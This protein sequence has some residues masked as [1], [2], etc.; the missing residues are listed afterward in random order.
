MDN[1][2]V[3]SN[4]YVAGEPTFFPGATEREHRCLVTVIK[5]RGKNKAGAEM[6]DEFSL[7]FWGKYACMAANYLPKGRAINVEGQLRSFTKDTGQVKPNG[8]PVLYRDTTIHV[9]SFEFSRD[10]RKT[11]IAIV[12][13]NILAAKAAGLL[14][15]NATVTAE[16]LLNQERPAYADFN[17]GIAEQSGKYVH[18]NVWVKGRGYI[19]NAA[20]PAAA[21]ATQNTPA[22]A[23]AE[24]NKDDEIAKLQAQLAAMTGGTTQNAS[25][26]VFNA[27]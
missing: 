9:K 27:A 2:T 21:P 12:D 15:P 7:V 8:K 26:D 10:S 4:V 20:A 3:L 18:A 14:D 16:Y 19:G 5:N 22:P 17:P 6:R 25:V 23:P 1:L 11:Q 13:R 24:V